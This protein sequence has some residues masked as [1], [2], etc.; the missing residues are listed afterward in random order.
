MSARICLIFGTL[1]KNL[2][3]YAA[4]QVFILRLPLIV[5]AS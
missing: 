2:K 1:A 3:P 5:L 4:L